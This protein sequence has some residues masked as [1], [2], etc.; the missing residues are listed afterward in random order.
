MSEKG[1]YQRGDGGLDMYTKFK[2]II[3]TSLTV[4]GMAI[5]WLPFSFLPFL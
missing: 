1:K 2:N 3:F 4:M 5:P